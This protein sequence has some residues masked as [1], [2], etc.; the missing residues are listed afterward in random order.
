MK[1]NKSLFNAL[2][3]MFFDHALRKAMFSKIEYKKGG[4]VGDIKEDHTDRGEKIINKKDLKNTP[5]NIN[6]ISK[7][8]ISVKG[9]ENIDWKKI[10]K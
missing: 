10:K 5:H 8:I 2:C 3:L 7:T 4:F 6:N 1:R 9:F